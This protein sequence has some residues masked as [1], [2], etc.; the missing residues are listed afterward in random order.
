MYVLFSCYCT[1]WVLWYLPQNVVT[2]WGQ[3][4]HISTR[5]QSAAFLSSLTEKCL[6]ISQSRAAIM[7]CASRCMLSKYQVTFHG[8]TIKE[9]CVLCIYIYLFVCGCNCNCLSGSQFLNFVCHFSD[10]QKLLMNRLKPLLCCLP[11][12]SV[13]CGSTRL[14]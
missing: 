6:I 3:Y 8:E 12:Y 11:E 1:C 10:L 7:G 13:Q 4:L 2:V 5:P 14:T 9:T